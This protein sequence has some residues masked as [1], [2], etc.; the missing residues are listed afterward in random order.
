MSE[1]GIEVGRVYWTPFEPRGLV[2]VIA[3]EP[4]QSGYPE[5]AFIE[6]VG[7]HPHGYESGSHGR[8]FSREL[9]DAAREA[10]A[11]MGTDDDA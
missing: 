7:D 9:V 5:C 1:H 6:F 11:T 3:I 4:P 8:Y 10:L 2:K